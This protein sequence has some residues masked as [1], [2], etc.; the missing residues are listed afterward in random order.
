[1]KD[2]LTLRPVIPEDLPIFF[3]HQLDTEANRMA[4]FTSRD[5]NDRAAFDAHWKKITSDPAVILR[6]ILVDG[7]VVGHVAKYDRDGRPEV[8]YWIGREDW[9]RGVATAALLAFLREIAVRPLFAA[10][11]ADNVAS[12]RIL[13]KCG[14]AR[15]GRESSFAKARGREIDEFF[16]VL[17]ADEA[18]RAT[19]KVGHESFK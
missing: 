19:P 2:A 3:H 16:F 14:F 9:G 8:T 4:A 18:S 17:D 13:E 15:C 1:L 10:A 12:I 7:R 11:A 5:P 6:T